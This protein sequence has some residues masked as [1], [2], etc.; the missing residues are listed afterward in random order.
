[1]SDFLPVLHS[2]DEFPV[3]QMNRAVRLQRSSQMAVFR[4]GLR[5]REKTER[6]RLDLQ[7]AGDVVKSA[8]EEE[9]DLLE[10]A[11]NRAEGSP[12]RVEVVARRV[13]QFSEINDRII[14]RFGR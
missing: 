8:V 4:H 3:R 6:A 10:W 2:E 14:G 12:A 7:A 9:I 13:A 5:A 1:M 11:M